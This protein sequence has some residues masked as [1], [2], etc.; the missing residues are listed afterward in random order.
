MRTA[1]EQTARALFAPDVP[2]LVPHE[3]VSAA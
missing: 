1:V 2:R 3:A